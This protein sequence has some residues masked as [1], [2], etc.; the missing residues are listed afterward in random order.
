MSVITD[1][2]YPVENWKEIIFG[3]LPLTEELDL[4]LCP[5]IH[6][7]TDLKS[8]M[9]S[10]CIDFIKETMVPYE[11]ILK[12]LKD[13]QWEGF[14]CTHSYMPPFMDAIE[15]PDREEVIYFVEFGHNI[16]KRRLIIV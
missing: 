6:I 9:V 12:I 7:P 1:D 14:C 13:S 10:D 8:K 4:K 16:H 2:L 3:V 15:D 11:E 5:E